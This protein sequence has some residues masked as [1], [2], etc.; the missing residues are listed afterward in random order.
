M[1]PKARRVKASIYLK[2]LKILK[3][4]SIVSSLERGIHLCDTS[5]FYTKF[6]RKKFK[7]KESF[8][9]FWTLTGKLVCS[10]NLTEINIF[11]VNC[12]KQ[13]ARLINH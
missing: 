12:H 6:L 1:N 7:I 3:I 8:P 10:E 4:Y 9:I 13:T 5:K 11:L 2:D